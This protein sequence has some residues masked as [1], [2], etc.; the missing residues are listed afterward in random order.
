[1]GTASSGLLVTSDGGNSWRQVDGVPTD[2]PVNV[3]AQDPQHPT[4]VYVG[5]KQAFYAT[6]DGGQH[7][8]RRGGNLPFGDFTSIIINPRNTDELFV[9]NAYQNG[10]NG[11]GVYHSTNA[12]L[13]WNRIDPKERKLPSFRIWS[14]ALDPQN[15]GP[16]FVGSHSAGIYVVPRSVTR[17][18]TSLR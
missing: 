7:W 3:V 2:A 16:L 17:A 14:L 1:V 6:H 10:D 8:Q 9:G 4:N 5:T 11:G 15:Q 12:G 13:T 18:S